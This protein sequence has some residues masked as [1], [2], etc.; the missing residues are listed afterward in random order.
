[1][2]TYVSPKSLYKRAFAFILFILLYKSREQLIK[3]AGARNHLKMFHSKFFLSLFFFL[4]IIFSQSCKKE[5]EIEDN[6]TNNNNTNNNN[7]NTYGC[8]DT[9]INWNLDWPEWIF[10]H[11]VWYDESTQQS[12]QQLVD[13]YLA[14]DIPVGAIIIDSPWETGYNTFDWDHSLYP[15]PQGM[16]DY[17]HSK[18]VRVLLWIT[19]AMNFDTTNVPTDPLR[20]SLYDYAASR[21]YFMQK[22]ATSGP[23][24]IKWWKGW[25][26]MIDLFNPD[27]VAWWKSLMD[28]VLDMG[29]DGWKCDGTDYN[30]IDLNDFPNIVTYFYSPGKG[31]NITREEYSDAYYRLFHEYTRQRLGNDRVNMSRPIDNYGATFLSGSEVAFTPKDIAWSSWVGDQNATFDGLKAALNNMYHSANYGYLSFGSDI[32]GYREDN[33]YP[34]NK[35]SKELFI[36]WAQLGAFSPLME[37]GGGGEHRPWMFDKQTEDIYRKLAKLRQCL[38]PYLM[39]QS[40]IAWDESRSMM[41]FFND[42][43]YSFLLGSDI[44]VAPFLDAGTDITV[45]FPSGNKWVYLYDETKIYDGGT[46]ATLTITYDEFPAFYKEGSSLVDDIE[47]NNIQ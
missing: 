35:R 16:I 9:T 5:N 41:T 29:I 34:V 25:G 2:N 22:D 20:D 31:G 46:T 44:F 8:R 39:S 1:M 36:R 4:L 42:N 47:F 43:D 15:D 27:A 32:G 38:I 13:D 11:W 45:T 17:F 14:H 23:G 19:T 33:M 24:K 26:S 7:N 40:K 3:F 30:L 37:N 12:A 28:K 21:N 6:N 10:D 18:N